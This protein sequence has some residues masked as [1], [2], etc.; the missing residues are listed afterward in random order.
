MCAHTH[1]VSM[2]SVFIIVQHF[3][4]IF[5]NPQ[6]GTLCSESRGQSLLLPGIHEWAGS[7]AEDIMFSLL[8]YIN[9]SLLFFSPIPQL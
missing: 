2:M 3:I 6:A 9:E 7:G 5:F 4:I 8:F 1:C